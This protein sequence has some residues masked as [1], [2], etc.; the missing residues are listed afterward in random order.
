[1]QV[2]AVAVPWR[3]IVVN[4]MTRLRRQGQYEVTRPVVRGAGT[5]L[6]RLSLVGLAAAYAAALWRMPD[7]M[8]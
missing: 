1:M 6:L 2:N 8:H 4:R 5:V 3:L 7:W